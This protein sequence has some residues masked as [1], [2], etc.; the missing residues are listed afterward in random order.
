MVTFEIV[1]AKEVTINGVGLLK[2]DEPVQLDEIAL[3]Q[4]QAE[5]G[6]PIAE[7]NFPSYVKLTSVLASENKNGEEV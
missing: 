1:S 7:A 6:Y 4:F 2:P 5:H 3:S